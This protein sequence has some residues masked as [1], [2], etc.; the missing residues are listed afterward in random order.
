MSFSREARH[1]RSADSPWVAYNRAADW[2]DSN[3]PSF[4]EATSSRPRS[5][6]SFIFPSR[7]RKAT[8]EGTRLRSINASSLHWIWRE[9]RSSS[10]TA[11]SHIEEERDREVRPGPRQEVEVGGRRCLVESID[12]LVERSGILGRGRRLRDLLEAL[13]LR[14]QLPDPGFDTAV[15]LPVAGLEAPHL[16]ALFGDPVE[17]PPG[18]PC[19]IEVATAGFPQRRIEPGYEA[20]RETF[21]LRRLP[22]VGGD[23]LDVAGEDAHLAPVVHLAFPEEAVDPLAVPVQRA[24]EDAGDPFDLLARPPY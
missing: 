20:R 18:F 19:S 7:S 13:D 2:R 14:L 8:I 9:R 6:A 1:F 4:N 17:S 21:L 11:L 22:E 10:R 12:R 24:V 23:R 5:A 3:R 16:R 15:C